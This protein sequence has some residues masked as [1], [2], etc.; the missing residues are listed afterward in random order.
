ML[1]AAGCVGLLPTLTFVEAGS[2]A[3]LG[4]RGRAIGEGRQHGDGSA[5]VA[6][7]QGDALRAGIFAS[8][9][10]PIRCVHM[11]HAAT[12]GG[13]RFLSP[14]YDSDCCHYQL[15]GRA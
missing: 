9:A 14:L 2:P 1:F 7:S 12:L 4:I 5:S 8:G 13:L 15:A 6:G 11:R 3:Q 10:D